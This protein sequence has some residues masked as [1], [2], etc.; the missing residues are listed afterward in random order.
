MRG[1]FFARN[2]TVATYRDIL[3][4]LTTAVVVVDAASDRSFRISYLNQS[5]QSLFGRSDTRTLGIPLARLIH[6]DHATPAVLQ[7]VLDTGQPFT[8][9]EVPLYVVD[10]LVRVN[11]SISPLSETELLVEFERLDR[12]I[13]IDRD[14]RHVTL[15]E[16]VRKL[17]RGLAHEIKN[18]L[19]GLRGAAQLLDRQLVDDEQREYTSVIISEADRLR[20]LVDRIMGPNGEVS[21]EPVNV[22]HV[23]ERVVKL[24][25]AESPAEV[26]FE[27]S[28]DPSLPHVEA[29]FERLVQATLNVLGNATLALKDTP[30]PCI[31]LA[32]RVVRQFTIGPNRHRLVANVDFIDNGPG[33]PADIADRIFYPMI[34]GRAEGSGLGLA[35]TQTIIAQHNGLI[36]CESEPGRTVFSFYL[37]ISQPRPSATA[38]GAVPVSASRSVGAPIEAQSHGQ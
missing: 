19:G 7:D 21:F 38:N 29:D 13:R 6:D 18:P 11:Y 12:F 32:T 36:E 34:S 4:Q 9:R 24:L 16:T 27:R 17:A 35:I 26:K 5:A 31:R 8:K 23:I 1:T 3:D 20:N 22:H 33:V 2:P 14:E 10:G 25:E 30:D 37:P 15:Q 28:Y